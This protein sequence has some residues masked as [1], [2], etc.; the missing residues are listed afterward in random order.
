M[1]MEISDNK[2]KQRKYVTSLNLNQN[3]LKPESWWQIVNKMQ[4]IVD[5]LKWGGERKRAPKMKLKILQIF[6]SKDKNR[7]MDKRKRQIRQKIH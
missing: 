5:I 1:N 6:R 4:T 7:N 3:S 2:Q